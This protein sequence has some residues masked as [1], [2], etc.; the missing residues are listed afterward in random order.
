MSPSQYKARYQNLSVPLADGSSTTIRVNQYRLRSSKTYN[1]AAATAFLDKLKKN[2]VDMEL[3]VDTGAETFRIV[4]RTADGGIQV[5]EQT[6]TGP[7]KVESSVLKQVRVMARYVF[8]GKGAPEDC[9]IVLQ[10]AD[11]W[12][13]APGGLQKYADD[14]LGLDC[15]GFVG[16]YLWHIR[17][18][19]PWSSLGVGNL[20]LGP[21]AWISGY[22]DGKKLLSRWEDI[23]PARSYIMGLV[24][25][26]GNIIHGGPG[27]ATGH[28]VITEPGRFRPATSSARSAVWSVES[29][30]AHS[31]GLWES[32]YSCLR[33]DKS[34]KVFTIYRE[35]MMAGHQIYP[36]KI[37]AV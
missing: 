34:T 18:G 6:R 27:S 7:V 25:G 19:H 1:A 28:I 33:V 10:L 36:F 37:A 29:T 20:D 16:N 26:G 21:D 23:D 15:N 2:G 14:A 31:P 11:H 3:R 9:Q 30:G 8:A 12:N 22:F 4:H 35:E 17:Y 32:W 13:L 5:H 24:D